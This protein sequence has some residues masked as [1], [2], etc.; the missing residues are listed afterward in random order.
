MA[1]TGFE[2]P[3][4]RYLIPMQRS[5]ALKT[6]PYAEPDDPEEQ[7]M[8][9]LGAFYASLSMPCACPGF[10]ESGAFL[11][12]VLIHSLSASLGLSLVGRPNDLISYFL[13]P[14]AFCSP[15]LYTFIQNLTER[16][17]DAKMTTARQDALQRAI[18]ALKSLPHPVVDYDGPVERRTKAEQ[19]ALLWG[20]IVR[21][22]WQFRLD[23]LVLD[24]RA[25][26]RRRSPIVRRYLASFASS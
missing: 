10:Y 16:A 14:D 3:L 18:K 6:N 20:E 21:V 13:S 7:A 19:R 22:A 8:L 24:V 26:P 5:L 2:R 25:G 1:R 23:Q 17:K 11:L 12:S 9:Y 15:S 4:D